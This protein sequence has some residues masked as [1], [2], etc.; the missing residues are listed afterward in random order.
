MTR[1]TEVPLDRA[2]AANYLRTALANGRSLSAA[3]LATIDFEAGSFSTFLPVGTSP[4]DA[5]DFRSGGKFGLPPRDRWI[6]GSD[7]STAIPVTS[8]IAEVAQALQKELALKG[9]AALLENPMAAP[10]DPWVE[11]AQSRIG[12]FGE[13]VY[14]LLV[15]AD[16]WGRILA[17][18]REAK[19]YPAPIGAVAR[20]MAVQATG[21]E[22][23]SQAW[24]GSFAAAAQVVFAEAYDG[25]S[26]VFWRR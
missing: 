13:E 16:D 5:I 21:I 14:H 26:Y 7:G 25:E 4:R 6:H 19:G 22:V 8:A 23:L 9:S 15:H 1:V 20:P 17:S 3:L 2:A 24:L 10:S 12:R 18:L 11:Q